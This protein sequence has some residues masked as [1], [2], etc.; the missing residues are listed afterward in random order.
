VVG[1]TWGVEVK[2]L[3]APVSTDGTTIGADVLPF[4]Q[5]NALVI[6]IVLV[7]LMILTFIF[8]RTT[9][10]LSLKAS[11]FSPEIARLSGVR[12]D[13]TRT[14]GWAIAGACGAIAGVLATPTALLSPNSLDILL[15][16]GFAAAVIGGL[17]SMLGAVVGG[18]ILGLGVTFVSN[19]VGSTL[20]FFSAFVFLIFILLVKPAGLISGKRRRNA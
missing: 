9:L 6:L 2:S 14:V 13:L 5:Y 15:V 19:Y 16:F 10:G 11:A 8:Q 18:I 4:S 3:D 1:Y 17:E 12:V 7:V 20:V